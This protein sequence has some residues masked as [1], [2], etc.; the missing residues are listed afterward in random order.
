MRWVIGTRGTCAKR[1]I[2]RT[3]SC[4]V[5]VITWSF[6]VYADDHLPNERSAL[7][8][9]K[10]DALTAT[11][12]RPLFAPSRRKPPPPPPVAAVNAPAPPQE[13]QQQQKRQLTLQGIIKDPL[14]T[15]ILLRD[16]STSESI[17]VRSGETVGKWRVFADSSYSVTLKDGAEELKLEMF[18]LP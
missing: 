11:R 6:C 1:Q 9:L 16:A 5:A 18:A 2:G 14:E 13:A 4:I 8:W 17:T 15:L 3:A 7:P 12:D 10:L